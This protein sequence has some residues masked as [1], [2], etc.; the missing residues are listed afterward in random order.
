MKETKMVKN[1]FNN[2]SATNISEI[3]EQENETETNLI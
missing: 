2:T 1:K 3:S